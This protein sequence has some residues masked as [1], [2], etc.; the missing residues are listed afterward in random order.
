MLEMHEDRTPHWMKNEVYLLRF[1]QKTCSNLEFIP[2]Y[3]MFSGE[4]LKVK[5]HFS[6]SAFISAVKSWFKFS[7]KLVILILNTSQIQRRKENSIL[8]V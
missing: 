8:Q 6:S 3:C 2:D 4:I 5:L 1:L 7:G